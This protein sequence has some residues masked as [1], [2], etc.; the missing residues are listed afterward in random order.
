M[1]DD[2]SNNSDPKGGEPSKGQ[3]DSQ[4]KN[5]PENK[6]GSESK[7]TTFDIT[8]IPDD[9]FSKVLE[10]PRLYKLDR[11]QELR[12]G[13]KKAKE[14]E[15]AQNKAKE[16]EAKKQGK[17]EELATQREEKIAELNKQIQD[18]AVNSAIMQEASK[19]GVT[20]LDL[21]NKLVDKSKI[22]I[23]ENGEVSG[24]EDAVKNLIEQNDFL[25][26]NT[27]SSVGGGSNPSGN[28]NEGEFTISQ[29]QDPI[30]Y[31]K[32]RDAIQRAQAQGKI[33]EDRS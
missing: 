3:E 31:Q 16:E 5:T 12:E 28:T 26:G 10:D 9:Q 21:V 33:I 22:E 18:N 27:K 6:S 17:W 25:T 23:S 13:A 24:V 30:F 8:K 11:I 14:L 15:E 2:K 4:G 29:I 19:Q 20:R 1:A 7:E 32:N